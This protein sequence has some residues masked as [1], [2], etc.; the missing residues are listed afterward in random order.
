MYGVQLDRQWTTKFKVAM[1][2]IHN[3]TNQSKPRANHPC[4]Y[5]RKIKEYKCSSFQLPDV[6]WRNCHEEDRRAGRID[7][8]IE[9]IR[10][11]LEHPAICLNPGNLVV[12]RPIPGIWSPAKIHPASS[13][14]EPTHCLVN[15]NMQKAAEKLHI[16]SPELQMETGVNPVKQ[17]GSSEGPRVT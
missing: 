1:E 8:V 12:L 16:C 6:K 11:R 14:H 10:P 9:P 13:E 4:L 3:G 17:K 7:V 2:I 15:C 5:Q